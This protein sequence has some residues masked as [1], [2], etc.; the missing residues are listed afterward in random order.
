MSL[1]RQLRDLAAS[2]Y[3]CVGTIEQRGVAQ[4]RSSTVAVV[5]A[6][7]AEVAPRLD[8]AQ[9]DLLIG[10]EPLE[11]LRFSRTLRAG[12]WC[13]LSNARVETICGCDEK[14]AYPDTIDVIAKIEQYGCRC[15]VLDWTEYM[16]AHSMRAVH[17]SSAM[18]GLFCAVFGFDLEISKSMFLES[19]YFSQQEILKN[20]QA[21]A[22]GFNLCPD[23]RDSAAKL[24]NRSDV[25]RCIM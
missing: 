11:A 13:F 17:I 2:R 3:P 7:Y 6:S 25:I 12:S 24:T 5:L 23:R 19:K 18:L 15:I 4:K 16:A 10:M 22:W 8:T 20:L 14:Y 1:C 9:A 21:L